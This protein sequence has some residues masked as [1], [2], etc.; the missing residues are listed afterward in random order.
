M[1]SH[2]LEVALP[3]LLGTTLALG[4]GWVAAESYLP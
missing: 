1:L 2:W 3:L 4:L